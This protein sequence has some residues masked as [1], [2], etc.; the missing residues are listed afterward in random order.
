MKSL[1]NITMRIIG[2]NKRCN[3]TRISR[4]FSNKVYLFDHDT[5]VKK[6]GISNDDNSITKFRS[7]ITDNFS[8]G[9]APNGGYLMSIA[10]K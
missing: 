3:R 2:F 4:L 6:I 5:S 1:T 10:I 8:I 9:D 7:K